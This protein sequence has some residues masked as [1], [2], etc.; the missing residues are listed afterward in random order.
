[1]GEIFASSSRIFVVL[2]LGVFENYNAPVPLRFVIVLLF[3]IVYEASRK[4]S[5]DSSLPRNKS[6]DV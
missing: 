3:P 6:S 2:G 5:F 4:K 1:M